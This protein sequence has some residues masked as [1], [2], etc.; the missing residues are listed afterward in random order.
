MFFIQIADL[1]PLLA[2]LNP[3]LILATFAG[4]FLLPN[5]LV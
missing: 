5:H 4:L 2:Y 3:S 1:D